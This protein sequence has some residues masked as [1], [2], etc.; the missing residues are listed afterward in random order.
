MNE[1]SIIDIDN[2]ITIAKIMG[3]IMLFGGLLLKK[4]IPET[5]VTILKEYI[6]NHTRKTKQQKKE[7]QDISTHQLFE[8]ITRH[9]ETDIPVIRYSCKVRRA[10]FTDIIVIFFNTLKDEAEKIAIKFYKQSI[11]DTE[12]KSLLIS[13]IPT[14]RVK[15]LSKCR[16]E[17]IPEFALLQFDDELNRSLG[18]I[19]N[20]IT[21]TMDSQMIYSSNYHKIM[22]IFNMINGFLPTFLNAIEITC[23]TINGKF[24][25]VTYKNIKCDTSVHT[26][27][28]NDYV[29]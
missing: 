2:P 25:T 19:K 11:S 1:Q 26:T 8:S 21:T 15:W 18:F 20:I 3:L 10:V 12:I 14:T 5:I 16:N 29:V 13:F 6:L 9:I 28:N 17:G 23:N 7:F 24:A 27:S 4:V 22:S